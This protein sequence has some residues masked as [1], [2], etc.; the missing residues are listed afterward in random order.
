[1]S[2]IET[3]V[4]GYV[5]IL[6]PQNIAHLVLCKIGMT[7]KDPRVRCAEINQTSTTGDLL[8]GVHDSVM[9]DDCA[10]LESLV[11]REL[12]PYRQ[13]S[14]ELFGLAAADAWHRLREILAGSC[15]LKE[16]PIPAP[17]K[18]QLL[19]RYS[20][21]RTARRPVDPNPLL[22]AFA[23]KFQI[24]PRE[25]G[26]HGKPSFGVSDDAKGVQWNIGIMHEAGEAFLGVN[27]EGMKY[28]GWPIATFILS[29]IAY[30][31]LEAVKAKVAHPA[32]ILLNISRDA[33]RRPRGRHVIVEQHI[34]DGPFPLTEID[35]ARWREM[36][37]EARDCLNRAKN[38][39]GRARQPV[40]LVK[41]GVVKEEEVSP[42]VSTK[43][44]YEPDWSR[45]K[46]AA[47]VD[48]AVVTLQPIYDWIRSIAERVFPVAPAPRVVAGLRVT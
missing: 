27:L 44:N 32:S 21:S 25:F 11:H 26:Q 20:L 2:K 34:A 22:E 14:R 16:I 38:W 48:Q 3:Q 1:M 40:T 36:L 9:V 33:R 47:A 15:R 6:A 28:F 7:T 41:S 43:I 29:E 5:Y 46:L 39:R 37:L 8:W 30:P 17:P 10:A 24:K 13:R 31:S 12:E 42:H 19:P 45:D 23:A 18:G 35:A 4:A